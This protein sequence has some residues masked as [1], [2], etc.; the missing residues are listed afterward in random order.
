MYVCISLCVHVCMC[1]CCVCVCCVCLNTL[2]LFILKYT[3]LAKKVLEILPGMINIKPHLI[4][5]FYVSVCLSV[6]PSGNGNG[7]VF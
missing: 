4:L 5:R 1:V 3:G 6:R 2:Q 7:R